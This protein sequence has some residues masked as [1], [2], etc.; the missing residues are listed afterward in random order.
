MCCYITSK[1]SLKSNSYALQ[2]QLQEHKTFFKIALPVFEEHD[3]LV[4]E[5]FLKEGLL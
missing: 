4:V 1:Y 5:N 3:Q 2:E